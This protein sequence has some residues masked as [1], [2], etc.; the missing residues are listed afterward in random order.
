[1][2]M[3][4][5]QGEVVARRVW[6]E[7][8]FTLSIK[9]PGVQ[10][11]E[12][13]QFLQL[14]IEQPDKHLHRPYS[15]A[16]PHGDVLDFYIVLV[17]DGHLTPKLWAMQEGERI[18]VSEK[19]AGS[20]TLSHAPFHPELWLIGTGTGLAPYIA[21]LRTDEVWTRYQKIILVHGVRYEHELAYREELAGHA[22]VHADRFRYV[23]VVSRQSPPNSL[24]GRITHCLTDG[25]LESAAGCSF[26]PERSTVF[27]CGNPDMLTEME[28]ELANRQVVRHK[29]KSPGQMVLERYW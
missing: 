14:G 19:A 8:L 18:D 21:M 29:P 28:H 9:A 23:P 22:L 12:P 11:F 2:A 13:G 3:H 17:E 15:V 1:M 6:A 25:S 27:L 7:G 10:P 16:S 26:H 20:F 4:W 24:S 5:V